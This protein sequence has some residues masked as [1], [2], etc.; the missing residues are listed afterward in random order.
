MMDLWIFFGIAIAGGIVAL[1]GFFV[2]IAKRVTEPTRALYQ[3][4][5]TLEKEIDDLKSKKN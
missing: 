1:L 2:L 3:R 4:I 5:E